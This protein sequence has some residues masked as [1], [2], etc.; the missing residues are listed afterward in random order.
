MFVPFLTGSILPASRGRGREVPRF[1][2]QYREAKKSPKNWTCSGFVKEPR[3]LRHFLINSIC[4][5]GF[6]GIVIFVPRAA[7]SKSVANS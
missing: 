2:R 4:Q 7:R 3:R 1:C 5:F 6:M